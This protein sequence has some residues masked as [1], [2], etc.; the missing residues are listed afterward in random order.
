MKIFIILELL[1]LALSFSLRFVMM[2]PSYIYCDDSLKKFI[3]LTAITYQMDTWAFQ[4]QALWCANNCLR[5]HLAHTFRKFCVSCKMEYA[6]PWT[7]FKAS[8]LASTVLRLFSHTIFS[9]AWI[10]FSVLDVVGPPNLS[11]H[12]E[13]LPFLKL[14]IH[15]QILLCDKQLLY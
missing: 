9:V 14:S 3:S 15:L 11:S 10:L 7:M 4:R 2:R 8:A 5:S 12:T 1:L 6:G 13:V